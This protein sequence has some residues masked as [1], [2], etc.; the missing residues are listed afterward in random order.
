M[1]RSNVTG[2]KHHKKGKKHRGPV[3]TN[4]D[5]RIEYAG[6]NQIYGL[7]KKKVGGSR[8]HVEC[9]DGKDRSALI[10]GKFFKKVWMN[11]GD[12]VLCDLNVGSDDTLCY[13]THKYTNR[14]ANILKSQGKITFDVAEDKE[15]LGNFKYVDGTK[16][17]TGNKDDTN[18]INNNSDDESSDDENSENSDTD[19][20][21]IKN[22]NRKPEIN[23][24][25][26]SD[27]ESSDESEAEDEED[28][29]DDEYITSNKNSR[30]KKDIGLDDL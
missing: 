29:D 5:S 4:Q 23:N 19:V 12:I 13:I 30:S 16:S 3:G 18:K 20:F 1:P 15:E 28:E 24:K 27:D 26:N 9:S 7:V 8:L 17:N 2:G 6:M 21:I 25:E 22:P 10:P 11:V 14:D